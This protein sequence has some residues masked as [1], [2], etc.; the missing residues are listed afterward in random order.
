VSSPEA[1]L[2]RCILV[3]VIVWA[4]C[5]RPGCQRAFEDV[6][7]P[8]GRWA[9]LFREAANFLGTELLRDAD[10]SGRYL[11]VDRWRSR[12]AY[13]AFRAARHS[14][15]ETLDR[16]CDTLTASEDLVGA[17]QQLPEVPE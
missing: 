5:P 13:E 12:A 6:Y 2:A 1:V 8:A 14:D 17:F 11:T 16:V 10:G 15:Y 9:T 4:F 7:G 3:Y